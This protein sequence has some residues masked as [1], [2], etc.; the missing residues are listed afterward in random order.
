MPTLKTMVSVRV[1]IAPKDNHDAGSE[2]TRRE[3]TWAGRVE[4]ARMQILGAAGF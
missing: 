3:V 4:G 2:S 1:F